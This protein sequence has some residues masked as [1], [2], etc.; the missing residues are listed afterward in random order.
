MARAAAQLDAGQPLDMEDPYAES[1]ST[2][3]SVI[4]EPTVVKR[5]H[6]KKEKNGTDWSQRKAKKTARRRLREHKV[7]VIPSTPYAMIVTFVAPTID[8]LMLVRAML[9]WAEMWS[10]ANNYTL[11]PLLLIVLSLMGIDDPLLRKLLCVKKDGQLYTRLYTGTI[12]LMRSCVTHWRLTG[13][14]D[15]SIPGVDFKFSMPDENEEEEEEEDG[16]DKDDDK[17]SDDEAD[18]GDDEAAHFDS[19]ADDKL[20]D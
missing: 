17:Y 10:K 13:D 16:K 3:V 12:S 14:Y 11:L 15:Y 18:D 19:S 1:P 6:A 9:G 20:E 2:V 7:L 8:E 4:A 5:V